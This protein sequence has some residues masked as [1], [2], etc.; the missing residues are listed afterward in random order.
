MMKLTKEESVFVKQLFEVRKQIEALEVEKETQM[1]RLLTILRGHGAKDA[2]T[3]DHSFEIM[4]Y[5]ANGREGL[6]ILSKL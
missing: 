1:D 3:H 6:L 5:Q 2:Y 4:R